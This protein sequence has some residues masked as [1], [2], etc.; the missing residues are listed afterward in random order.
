MSTRSALFSRDNRPILLVS[1]AA[2]FLLGALQALYGP[3]F[4]LLRDRFGVGLEQVSLVVSAQ[5]LGSFAAIIGSSELL[6]RFGYRRVLLAGAA[7]LAVGMFAI[8]VVPTWSL[9][10]AGAALGGVGFGLLNVSVNLMVAVAF[11]PNAAP[12]LNLINAVFGLGAVVGPLLVAVS[13]PRFGLPFIVVG[14]SGLLLMVAILNLKAPE[15]TVPR[16][17]ALPLAWANVAGFVMLYVFYVSAEV[18]VTSWETE[19]LTPQFGAVAAAG[20]TSLYWGAITVGRLLATPLSAR[21]RPRHMVLGA[22]ALALVFMVLAHVVELAPLAYALVGLCL[23]PIFPTALAWLTEVFPERAE[24]VTPL[25]VAAANL[26]PTVTAPLIGLVVGFGGIGLIP[27]AL[28]AL[29]LLLVVTAAWLWAR[30][31]T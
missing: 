5:F 1:F 13:E 15:V 8:V 2:F 20:F 31:R 11:R 12:A 7:S 30:T 23:A 16:S 26:G 24:Q 10:L 18:G 9:L 29:T 6:R 28:S 25:V 3:S 14:A 19:Y 22:S 27:T 21:L 4:P 17:D